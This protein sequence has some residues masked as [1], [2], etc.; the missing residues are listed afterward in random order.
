MK[1]TEETLKLLLDKISKL[2]QRVAELEEKIGS[3]K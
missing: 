3:N 1:V 2:E